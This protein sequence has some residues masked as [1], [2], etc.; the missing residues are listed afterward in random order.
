MNVHNSH[1]SIPAPFSRYHAAVAVVDF[2]IC[3]MCAFSRFFFPLFTAVYN[4][5]FYG[6]LLNRQCTELQSNSSDGFLPSCS[7]ICS[8]V[9]F[10]SA[11]TS[12]RFCMAWVPCSTVV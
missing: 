9:L 4:R 3:N 8:M 11:S 1:N 2:T 6:L 10:N 12:R 7:V 5:M